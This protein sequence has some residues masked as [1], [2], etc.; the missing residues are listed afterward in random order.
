MCVCLYRAHHAYCISALLIVYICVFNCTSSRCLSC[1]ALYVSVRSVYVH[2]V[3]TVTAHE[4][5]QLL[6]PNYKSDLE[7]SQSHEVCS[8]HLV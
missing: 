7:S 5:L 8:T 4:A 6:M 3:V 2:F 1:M